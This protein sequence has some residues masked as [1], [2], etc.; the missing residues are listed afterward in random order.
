MTRILAAAILALASASTGARADVWQR[1]LAPAPADAA[2]DTYLRELR[3]GDEHVGLA[4]THSG[5]LATIREQVQ[6]AIQ[7][8]RNAAAARP[9]AAEPYFRIGSVLWSFYLETCDADPRY[10]TRSPLADCSA[11]DAINT[12]I[13]EQAIQA[14]NTFEAKAPLDPRLGSGLGGLLFSRA[15]VHT[16]LATRPH[17]EAAARDY[18]AILQRSDGKGEV[19]TLVWGNLAETYM[20][21]GRLDDAIDTYKETLRHGARI[22]TWYG[23]AVALDRDG[24]AALARDA[25]VAQRLAGYRLFREEVESVQAFYVPRGE[26]FYYYAL[27]EESFGRIDE[28]LDYWNRFIA[29]GAHPQYQPR[30]REHID[31]LL[32]KKRASGAPPRPPSDLYLD[33]R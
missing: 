14:W 12:A 6:R 31:A 4:T 20:M 15:I 11:P 1:A 25:I 32:A 10:S 3:E 26:V 21:L 9:S 33:L 8:Y 5:S 13:A 22:S 17:L 28:A 24:R 27:A 23:L 16:K 2:N 30:A 29:S 19:L 18:E 7:A